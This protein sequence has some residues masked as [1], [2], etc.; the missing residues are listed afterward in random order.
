[1]SF[2]FDKQPDLRTGYHHK[3]QY[4]LGVLLVL[5]SHQLDPTDQ[6]AEV[7]FSGKTSGTGSPFSQDLLASGTWL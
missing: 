1:V 5:F 7:E 2:L 3:S 6:D 4:K